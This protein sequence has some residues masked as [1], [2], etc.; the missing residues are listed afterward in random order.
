MADYKE[1]NDEA[2]DDVVGGI[3]RYVN[4]HTD[5]NA[6]VWASWTMDSG[7]VKTLKNGTRVNWTGEVCEDPVSGRTMYQIDYPVDG[8]VFELF[9]ER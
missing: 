2:L 6:T 9:L 1:L 3:S 5:A 7:R 4:T 8:W